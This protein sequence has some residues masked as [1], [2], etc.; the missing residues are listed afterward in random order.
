MQTLL[1]QTGGE[2][3]VF[4]RAVRERHTA[5]LSMSNGRE[6]RGTVY[7]IP[8]TRMTDLLE[9]AQERFIAVTDAV[10]TD[11]GGRTRHVPYVAVNKAQL[12]TMEDLGEAHTETPHRQAPRITGQA[13][14]REQEALPLGTHQDCR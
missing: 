13:G 7:L 9:R 1:S 12:V 3:G 8:D 14:R 10:V 5:C 2:T 4:E 6:I 11:P